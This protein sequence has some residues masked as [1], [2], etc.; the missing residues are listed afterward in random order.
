MRVGAYGSGRRVR[1][2]SQPCAHAGAAGVGRHN[3]RDGALLRPWWRG[4]T[5][6]LAP[7][8][9]CAHLSTNCDADATAARQ[10]CHG[11]WGASCGADAGGA[12]QTAPAVAQRTRRGA[13]QRRRRRCLP[14]PRL[15]RMRPP[16]DPC[17]A[18]R[19]FGRQSADHL[20]RA[21]VVAP[22]SLRLRAPRSVGDIRR[23]AC[24]EHAAR[25]RR[26]RV[27]KGSRGG[28]GTPEA[29]TRG[30]DRTLRPA[31]PWACCCRPCAS[32]GGPPR[33]AHCPRAPAAPGRGCVHLEARGQ[34]L[35]SRRWRRRCWW[36]RRGRC[37]R[38]AG[39]RVDHRRR[40]PNEMGD[41]G[42]ARAS[43]ATRRASTRGRRKR[44]PPDIWPTSVGAHES[45][46]TTSPGPGATATRASSGRAWRGPGRRA[47]RASCQRCGGATRHVPR[48]RSARGLLAAAGWTEPWRWRPHWRRRRWRPFAARP[49]QLKRR[50]RTPVA[51]AARAQQR[52]GVPPPWRTRHAY[53]RGA[54]FRYDCAG[55]D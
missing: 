37:G 12:G 45:P 25:R 44:P 55:T 47:P 39:R 19:L 54:S 15:A 9:R 53:R 46:R 41:G 50:A 26:R 31:E 7:P 38:R 35:R 1:L 30:C 5:A 40:I 4:A 21:V 36:Q 23:C 22:S 42:R 32:R 11:H 18:R 43:A 2:R 13:A 20:R 33:A 48:P 28:G 3:R 16:A 29:A 14:L 24:R 8:A 34:N 10:R 6:H 27:H 52:R 51:A 49:P 17:A